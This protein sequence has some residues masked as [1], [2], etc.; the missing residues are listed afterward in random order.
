MIKVYSKSNCIG[1]M[2]TTKQL[3]RQGVEYELL[4]VPPTVIPE[5]LSEYKQLPIVDTGEEHW[6]GFLPEKL[7]ALNA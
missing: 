2:A 3:D 1:C 6:S 7:A 5:H 4:K